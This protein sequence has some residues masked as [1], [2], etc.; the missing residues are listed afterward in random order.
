MCRNKLCDLACSLNKRV[1]N[2]PPRSYQECSLLGN[3]SE[4]EK[5][6]LANRQRVQLFPCA[7]SEGARQLCAAG[8]GTPARCLLSARVLVE[9][10]AGSFLAAEGQW[11]PLVI[12]GGSE[13]EAVSGGGESYLGLLAY[14]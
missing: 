13:N 5:R 11:M 3:A 9:G 14:L 8:R 4:A 10:A 2:S 12:L 6:R 7:V 1:V